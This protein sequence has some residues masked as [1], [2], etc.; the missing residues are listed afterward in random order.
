MTGKYKANN[1]P[2]PIVDKKPMKYFARV[3]PWD[4]SWL[5]PKAKRTELRVKRITQL[6]F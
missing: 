4:L 6:K 2:A 5:E 1:K 3:R